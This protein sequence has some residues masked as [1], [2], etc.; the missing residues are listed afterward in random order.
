MDKESSSISKE[1]FH[2]LLYGVNSSLDEKENTT[3]LVLFVHRVKEYKS[4]IYILI[5]NQRDKEALKEQ[6]HSALKWK[7]LNLKIYTYSK[8]EI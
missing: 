5:R 8:S 4:G 3:H 6:M 2:T 1:Q 7:N